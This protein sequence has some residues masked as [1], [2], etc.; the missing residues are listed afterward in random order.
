MH[1]H[2]FKQSNYPTNLI[3]LMVAGVTG[4][5][6]AAV[7]LPVDQGRRQDRGFA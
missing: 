2:L 3:Q 1:A 6:G 4:L 5:S 7:V